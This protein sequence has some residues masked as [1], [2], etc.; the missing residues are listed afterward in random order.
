MLAQPVI[1]V[2][3]HSALTA[4]QS[5]QDL[6]SA[7]LVCYAAELSEFDVQ[8][9]HRPGTS[10]PLAVPDLLSRAPF[11][12]DKAVRQQMVKELLEPRIRRLLTSCSPADR[13]LSGEDPEV[14]YSKEEMQQHL[15]LLVRG[16]EVRDQ[17]PGSTVFNEAKKVERDLAAGEHVSRSGV[18]TPDTID[19]LEEPR[20]IRAYETSVA[21]MVAVVDSDDDNDGDDDSEGEEDDEE[22]E[23]Q[24]MPTRD[25]IAAAQKIDPS[26]RLGPRKIPSRNLRGCFTA[27]RTEQCTTPRHCDTSSSS[28]KRSE[29]W[30]ARHCTASMAPTTG[31]C[32]QQCK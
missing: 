18:Y 32:S 17:E 2:T 23:E 8:I 12:E 25:Q 10:Q 27:L 24:Q 3:D 19:Q 30:S 13:T 7:R 14:V 16:A 5:K 4:L 31:E 22:D 28:Q 6:G 1:W 20:F 15:H 11:E 9:V 21:A 29:R 26:A